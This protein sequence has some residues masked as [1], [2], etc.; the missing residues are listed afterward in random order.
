LILRIG[1]GVAVGLVLGLALGAAFLAA[2]AALGQAPVMDRMEAATAAAQ[3]DDF[4]AAIRLLG[5][6]IAE[7]HLAG[8]ELARAHRDLG[9][10][11]YGRG[12]QSRGQNDPDRRAAA[13]RDIEQAIA[14]FDTSIGLNPADAQSFNRRG[15]AYRNKSPGYFEQAL[16]DFNMALRLKPDFA[17]A[18]LNRGMWGRS[19]NP[20]Q[21]IADF[22][23]AIRLAP[24]S[25]VGMEA[26]L[27][28]GQVLVNT[29][30]LDRA[31]ADYDAVISRDPDN[32]LALEDRGIAYRRK[33]DFTR[34]IADFDTLIRVDLET[35]ATFAEG[36]APAA[37]GELGSALFSYDRA[38]ERKDE[39]LESSG[40]RNSLPYPKWPGLARAVAVFD[41]LMRRSSREAAVR[42]G[43]AHYHLGELDLAIEDFTSVIGSKPPARF[44]PGPI[45]TGSRDLA[46]AYWKRAAAYRDKGDLDQALADFNDA[47]SAWTTSGMAAAPDAGIFNGLGLALM[48]KGEFARAVANFDR[49]IQAR[50]DY[51]PAYASRGIAKLYAGLPG[52]AEDLADAVRLVPSNPYWVIWLHIARTRAAAD[53][54]EEFAANSATLDRTRWPWPVVQLHLGASDAD[55]ARAEAMSVADSRLAPIYACEADFYVGALELQ[56]G[57]TDHARQLLQAAVGGCRPEAFEAVAARAELKRIGP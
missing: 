13:N 34:A 39:C 37:S 6:A 54:R 8:S 17:Q 41:A 15:L 5:E 32:V 53:D 35:I 30:D 56:T 14:E 3:R 23:E 51:A 28:R 45:G 4:D 26:R 9:S 43:S 25:P 49:M 36:T 19:G 47:V 18:Y 52:A 48:R 42:R 44:G 29:G 1:F 16:A 22:S 12:M 24:D 10:A 27:R 20:D 31:I 7:D 38:V 57:T 40:Y 55:S 33:G 46:V 50:R 2:T 11:L 21:T